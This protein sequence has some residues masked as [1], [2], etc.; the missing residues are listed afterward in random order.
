[1]ACKQRYG[2]SDNC[3]PCSTCGIFS[4]GFDEDLE[5][6]SGFTLSDGTAEQ[7]GGLLVITASDTRL[8]CDTEHPD[9]I[10]SHYVACDVDGDDD[11][12]EIIIWVGDHYA[13]LTI[14]DPNGCLGLYE[15]ADDT[16]PLTQMR[17]N[18]PAATAHTLKV[19]Y[20]QALG[21]DVQLCAQWNGGDTLGYKVT[22]NGNAVGI[23]TGTIT[24]EVHGDNF[25]Y[26][27]H[28]TEDD[29]TCSRATVDLCPIFSDGF[30]RANDTNVG[31]SFDEVA[32]DVEI[33]GNVMRTSSSN[34]KVL[35]EVVHPEGK[36]TGS[37]QVGVQG[38]TNDVFKVYAADDFYAQLILGTSKT[39][40]LFNA[41]AAEIASTTISG[42]NT[43]ITVCMSD[44]L[45]SAYVGST[46]LSA[47]V[48][49]P[50][51]PTK[52]GFG[53]GAIAGTVIFNQ[54]AFGEW[55]CYECYE[56]C[57]T[58]CC[59]HQLGEYVADFGAGGLTDEDCANCDLIAGEFTLARYNSFCQW[60]YLKSGFCPIEVSCIG[61]PQTAQVRL[62]IELE[63]ISPCRWRVTC[64][65]N[66]VGDDTCALPSNAVAV[67]LG[68]TGMT[69]C[70]DLP[71][72][73]TLEAGSTTSD[74]CEGSWPATITLEHP[75]A[76]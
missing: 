62:T 39:L 12:D 40:K 38:A 57:S 28:W 58:I 35:I 60:R 31:C 51:G 56:D 46:H 5:T 29:T 72:T 17:V 20:G 27:K 75:N 61:G 59:E 44:T 18:A 45:L 25:V 69:D 8:D 13:K 66:A 50:A 36:T 16:E 19:W 63:I 22:L 43:T 24:S 30:D 7:A 37:I 65:L 47:A 2:R 76:A 11:G 68:P 21:G 14:G 55:G 42:G 53:T 73:L 74:F 34:A 49:S 70:E 6:V 3:P 1:M 9:A 52:F 15:T 67:Y 10:P 54:V 71:V 23:G 4:S 33:N 32:G 64:T 48:T 41:A 26:E